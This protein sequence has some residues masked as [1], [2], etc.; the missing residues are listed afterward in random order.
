MTETIPWEKKFTK[1]TWS[2][3]SHQQ[4]WCLL[5]AGYGLIKKKS[6]FTRCECRKPMTLAWGNRFGEELRWIYARKCRYTCSTIKRSF[7][8]HSRLEF[9]KYFTHNLKIIFGI[10]Y[11]EIALE[12]S[13]S[14]EKHSNFVVSLGSWCYRCL[15]YR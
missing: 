1:S 4:S 2:M 6:F 14:R 8:M 15:Y 5:F 3:P 12:L 9:N 13:I 7:F 10:E 11:G